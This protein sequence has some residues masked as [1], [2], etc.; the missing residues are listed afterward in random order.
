[1]GS[2]TNTRAERV[3]RG[4]FLLAL[5]AVCAVAA[6]DVAIG[7]MA[8]IVK[9][10]IIGPVIAAFGASTRHTAIVAVLALVASVPLAL[11]NDEFG[12]TDHVT[13]V[14]AIGLVGGLAVGI[15]QLRWAREA[16]SARLVVQYGLARILAEADSF[17]RA[18]PAMLEAI[19]APLHWELGHLFEVRPGEQLTLVAGWRAPGVEA[20]EFEDATRRIVFERGVG[21]PGTVWQK[22]EPT[23][24]TDVIAAGDHTRA[25]EAGQAGLR[26][27]IAF[28]IWVDGEC[29]AIIE[30]FTRTVREPE[31]DTLALAQ[32]LG[33]LIGE[34][35]ESERA[36]EAVVEARDQLTAI[37]SGIADA[38]TAQGPDGHIVFA[39]DAAVELMGF[40]SLR[41]L[42]EAPLDQLRQRFSIYDEHGE[43]FPVAR[44]PGRRALAG[45]GQAEAV[46]R[47]RMHADGE[48]LWT[49][50]KATPIYDG[51]GNV[52]MAIN[53]TED[54]TT[55][56]RAERAQRFLSRASA[57]LSASLDPKEV[58]GQVAKLAVPEISDWLYIDLVVD[59]GAVE[60]VAAAHNDPERLERAIEINREHP[61]ALDAPKGVANVLRTGRSE[62]YSD[63]GQELA[64]DPEGGYFRLAR[65]LGMRSA[66]VAPMISRGRTV[67]TLTL[68]TDPDGR[69]FDEHDLELAEELA[70]RCATAIDNARL[71]AERAYIAR[72]LQQSLLPA[73]LPD[74]PGIEAAAR[75]RPTGQGNEVGGDFYDLFESGGAG[76]TV[77]MGD[78]CGKGPDA[79]AVTALARYTLRAAAMRERVPSRSLSLLNEALLRQRD[80]RRFCTVVYAYLEPDGDGGAR[81]GFASAGHP[82]PLLL[83]TDGSVEPVGDPG[84]LLGVLP[85]PRF[86]D[87]SLSLVRGDTLVFYTDGMVEGRGPGEVLDEAG[88]AALL[89]SCAG[90]GADAIAGRLEDA[91]VKAHGGSP[92]DD[93]AVLVLRVAE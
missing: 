4:I 27:G 78:V 87:R 14:L 13:S 56:I 34:F 7:H 45:E 85:D 29:A 59:G 83:R 82:P 53:V 63:L 19:G 84:T 55:H 91:A 39:N 30:F 86:E 37:L 26:G 43:P 73:E 76:W 9:L 41:E 92:R 32:A 22:G 23:W 10:L 5:A 46:M 48:E 61:L 52:V 24:L 80:D 51:D 64:A 93:I 25:A 58:L 42:I 12:S 66:I 54:H 89:A 6:I 88:L 49:N 72:T 3:E 15:A 44:Y 70:L 1:L 60:R 11:A 75:F 16:D 69:R 38:V 62:L 18:A 81:I 28:P 77:V 35:I 68:A 74:I 47:L 90:A 65:E 20:A 67:G 21:L 50:V 17:E 33:A 2:Q 40:S 31:E 57:L 71:F 79:A 8:M 36:G